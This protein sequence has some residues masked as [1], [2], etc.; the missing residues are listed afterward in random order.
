MRREQAE[1][2]QASRA[3]PGNLWFEWSR[4]LDD[5]SVYV[6]VEAFED[7]AAQAHVDSDHFRT[8]ME[9]LGE[10]LVERPEV[11]SRQVPGRTWDELGEI[12]M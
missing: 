10:A 7:D 3:E 4:S 8:A 11:V 2:T 12:R 6:L 9:S 1:F 5:P